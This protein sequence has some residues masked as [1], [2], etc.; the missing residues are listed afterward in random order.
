MKDVREYFKVDVF[1]KPFP[2]PNTK[3]Q[4][5]NQIFNFWNLISSTT[6]KEY[7]KHWMATYQT[8]ASSNNVALLYS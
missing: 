7:H 1:H 5:L 6:P 8:L 4:K 3:C 2:L